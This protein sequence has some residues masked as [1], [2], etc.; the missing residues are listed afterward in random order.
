MQHTSMSRGIVGN[1][2]KYTC[3]TQQ[4]HCISLIIC[5]VNTFARLDQCDAVRFRA[6]IAMFCC[7]A[8]H[9]V[10]EF[11]QMGSKISSGVCHC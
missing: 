4:M 1:G 10:D 6:C 7:S 9:G 3:K 8:W 11:I 2:Q 5:S